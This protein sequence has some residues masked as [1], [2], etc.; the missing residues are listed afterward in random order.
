MTYRQL[1]PDERYMLAALRRQGCNQSQIARA[2]GRHRSTV[3]RELGRNC[4]LIDG[5]Y[6]P[7]NAR[8][9]TNGRRRRRV[10]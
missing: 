10:R 5:Q 1:V 9:R 7:G 6:G 4:C 2:P 3:S 8:E